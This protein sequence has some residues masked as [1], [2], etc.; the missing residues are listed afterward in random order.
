MPLER[1]GCSS[2]CSARKSLARVARSVWTQV[3]VPPDDEADGGQP[4]G[5]VVEPGGRSDPGRHR[6]RSG[7]RS[8]RRP[9]AGCR[10]SGIAPAR[11]GVRGWFAA[12][13]PGR[14]RGRRRRAASG[15]DCCQW[16]AGIPAPARQASA[17]MTS[18]SGTS[19]LVRTCRATEWPVWTG[20]R[21]AVAE[22]SRSGSSR[23]LRSSAMILRSSPLQPSSSITSICGTTLSAI[24]P[25]NGERLA[26]RRAA[27]AARSASYA[28]RAARPAPPPPGMRPGR[29][30]PR[31]ARSRIGPARSPPRLWQFGLATRLQCAGR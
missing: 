21:T 4:I 22:T 13:R 10:S 8:G 5:V 1:T 9:C 2:Y 6:R 12:G 16:R 20:T 17:S 11:A 18:F 3:D 26:W 31:P 19:R 30:T 29:P 15:V 24:R 27:P 23:I 25:W 28:S 14:D 7:S